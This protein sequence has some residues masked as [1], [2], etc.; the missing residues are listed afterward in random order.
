LIIFAIFHY[1]YF[2]TLSLRHCHYWYYI[3]TLICH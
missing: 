1:W 3:S 2:I